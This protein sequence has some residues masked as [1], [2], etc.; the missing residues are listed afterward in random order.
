MSK[1]IKIN[2]NLIKNINKNAYNVCQ[3]NSSYSVCIVPPEASIKEE[4]ECKE[5]CTDQYNSESYYYDKDGVQRCYCGKTKI[6]CEQVKNINNVC[7]GTNNKN[8]VLTPSSIINKIQPPSKINNKNICDLSCEN[9]LKAGSTYCKDSNKCICI[10]PQIIQTMANPAI[11]QSPPQPSPGC[12]DYNTPTSIICKDNSVLQILPPGEKTV[13]YFNN[14]SLL[15]GEQNVDDDNSK[16]TN[17]LCEC[18]NV[19]VNK[20][21]TIFKNN[22]TLRSIWLDSV[23]Q[24]ND[25]KTGKD[26]F[27]IFKE[28]LYKITNGEFDKNSVL[29]AYDMCKLT[30]NNYSRTKPDKHPDWL[31]YHL[32][33]PKSVSSLWLNAT[34]KVCISCMLIHLLLNTLIPNTKN[35]EDSLIYAMFIPQKLLIN[36]NEKALVLGISFFIVLSFMIIEYSSSSLQVSYRNYFII[37]ILICIIGGSIGLKYSIKYLVYLFYIIPIIIAIFFCYIFAQK[38]PSPDDK[39]IINEK[40]NIIPYGCVIAAIVFMFLYIIMLVISND[41]YKY[42]IIYLIA[43]FILGIIFSIY[44]FNPPDNN[45]GS[46]FI[47]YFF[48]ESFEIKKFLLCG[49]SYS[50]YAVIIGAVIMRVSILAKYKPIQ[51]I[52][53]LLVTMFGI[54]PLATFSIIINFAIMKYSPAIELLFIIMWRI[55]GSLLNILPPSASMIGKIVLKLSGKR[56]TDKWVLPFLP[57]VIYIIDVYYFVSNEKKPNFYSPT[58]L[59]TGVK[60]TEMWFS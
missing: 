45:Q 49:F 24:S 59:S 7:D 31:K 18:D 2:K 17:A 5:K 55:A 23:N 56:V 41:R 43:N 11:L 47:K 19:I 6:S 20:Y 12:K 29:S 50:I 28:N 34:V 60:N 54:L 4:K 35:I 21:N 52:S 13:S 16:I 37:S 53:F 15:L 32:T 57:W 48:P 58:G 46:S 10:N 25:D 38:E 3:E 8:C 26:L 39:N 40:K 27:T 36:K 33:D 14:T 51:V 22:E 9:I 44:Y 30:N 1:Q 42:T